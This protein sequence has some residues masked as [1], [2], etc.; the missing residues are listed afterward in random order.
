MLM[1]ETFSKNETQTS[2]NAFRTL[3]KRVSNTFKTKSSVH[4]V[5]TSI[6]YFAHCLLKAVVGACVEALTRITIKVHL[7]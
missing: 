4:G 3:S 2:I 5:I 1:T 7:G 6:V